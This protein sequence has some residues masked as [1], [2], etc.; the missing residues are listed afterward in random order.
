MFSF[1]VC[2]FLIQLS[3][4]KTYSICNVCEI[5][6]VQAVACW[7]IPFGSVFVIWTVWDADKRIGIFWKHKNKQKSDSARYLFM[8]FSFLFF[9][10]VILSSFLSF[11]TRIEREKKHLYHVPSRNNL[12]FQSIPQ[13]V[14][15]QQQQNVFSP[16]HIY[17]SISIEHS[18]FVVVVVFIIFLTLSVSRDILMYL[19]WSLALQ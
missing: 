18:L 8:D 11:I 15:G 19:W 3:R 5:K 13:S 4:D 16:K 12:I 10:S 1:F 2:C 7:K 9:F 14:D 6:N 17:L